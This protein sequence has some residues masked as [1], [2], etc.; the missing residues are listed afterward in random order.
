M[1]VRVT[2]KDHFRE[3]RLFNERAAWAVFITLLL[4]GVIGGR[5]IY[6]QVIN[7]SHFTTLSDGNR[8]NIVAVP[9]MRGFIYDRNGVLLAQNIPSFSLEIIPEKA[10]NLDETIAAL[11]QL[12]AVSDEDVR[13]FYRQLRRK[14]PFHSIPLRFNLNDAEMARFAIERHHFP[15][16]ETA[17]RVV[18]HYPLGTLAVHAV[19]YVGRINEEELR[20]LDANY[21]ATDFIGKTGIER[22]YEELLHG[23]VGFKQ[24]EINVVGRALREL[25]QT[26]PVPGQSVYLTLDAALQQAAE[27]ALGE[28]R[29]AVVAIDPRNGDVLAFAS[30][31]GYDPNPFVTGIDQPS[32]DRLQNSPDTPL[33][34]RALR[35]QYP[36]GSTIKPLIGLAG[37][38]SDR[39]KVNT[40]SFCPGWFSLEGDSHRYRDWKQ[41]G[42]GMMNLESAIVESC[43]VFFYDLALTLGIDRIHDY[44]GLFG[45]G[46]LTG[47]DLPN[48]RPGLLPS[49]AWKRQQHNQPWYRGETVIAGIG[50]GYMLTTPLQLAHSTAVLAARGVSHTPRL[51]QAVEIPAS[52]TRQALPP[53]RTE[54]VAIRDMQ[55]WDNVIEAMRKVMHSPRGTAQAV[56]RG[57]PWPI[58]GKTGTAQVFG[59]RQDERYDE[60]NIAERLRDHALFVA[61][62]PIDDPRI[63][64]AVI[65]ENGGSGSGAAAPVARQVIDHYL[66]RPSS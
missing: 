35:G 44:L 32:Y 14:R 57:A 9:P 36:P 17:A 61:F 43:D 59:I 51:V 13:R 11:R 50:Q 28:R 47:I 55:D 29:G 6:L 22:H 8:I 12:V 52:G 16:V 20:Q 64:I 63:A 31:P 41:T 60:K 42:H 26:P 27:S 30:T 18:R 39:I 19:G 56:G 45:L 38:E 5:L 66:G 58:A 46:R 34:N 37:L 53:I 49:R 65:V 10:G 3:S 25:S 40:S 7:H 21:S 15:G 1:P 4:V 2:I 62:S 33:F 48:E 54:D 23:Q 24:V